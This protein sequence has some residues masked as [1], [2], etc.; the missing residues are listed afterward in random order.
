MRIEPKKFKSGERY[1]FMLDED[2]VPDFWVTFYVT[3]RLRMNKAETTIESY[4]KD[5]KHFR[6]WE[7][8]N[9]RDVLQEI[10]NGKVLSLKD[11]NSLREYCAYQVEAFK[12][13]PL[14]KIV[15]MAQFHLSRGQDKPTISAK[16]YKVRVT[17][18]ADFL[19]Y[20]GR[21]RGKHRPSAAALFD[22]LETM[23]KRLLRDLPKARLKTK[24]VD[25]TGIQDSSFEDFVAV[26]QSDSEHNPFKM[27]VVQFRNYLIVQ[28]LYETGFRP[29]ELLALRI[30]DIGSETDDPRLSIAR[31]HDSKDDPRAREPTAKTLGRSV[32]ISKGLRELLRTYIRQYRSETKLAKTHP[33]IFVSHKSKK[34]YYESGEPLCKGSINSLYKKIRK[35]N[36][37]R[38]WGISARA[39]R[40]FFNDQ[41]SDAFDK[42]KNEV[43]REVA[44]LEQ[45]GQ[46]EQAKQYAFENQITEA[47]E[48]EI[49]AELNGH[50]S[51]SSGATY[52]KRTTRKLAT[53]MRKRME[54][55]L[56][57][58]VKGKND[59]V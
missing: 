2:G 33:L 27:S 21:E 55:K 26:A 42:Q 6:R 47:R 19:Y 5:I 46:F 35:V 54:E 36:P 14:G 29:S 15:D 18:V 39:Y 23:K 51:L 40:H 49:R 7:A 12:E 22:E 17:R 45:L 57:H 16:Q 20:I 24:S 13:K 8:A 53:K 28:T 32:P 56:M 50:S 37:E 59:G 11:I 38:F 1:V 58:K 43:K 41:L 31:R 3:Q 44:R 10:Y 30:A 34:G 48:L 25:K 4:L 9:D 52:L